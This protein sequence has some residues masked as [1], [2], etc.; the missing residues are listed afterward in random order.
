MSKPVTT[1]RVAW[2]SRRLQTRDAGAEDEDLGR[3]TVPAAV[4]IIG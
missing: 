3:G 1:R 4:V 2:R